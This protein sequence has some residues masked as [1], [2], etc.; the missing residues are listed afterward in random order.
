MAGFWDTLAL[1]NIIK[2]FSVVMPEGLASIIVLMVWLGF[3][4]EFCLITVVLA[5][6][7]EMLKVNARARISMERIAT[8]VYPSGS[9]K[10]IILPTKAKSY[11]EKMEGGDH[12][13]VI[14]PEG[15]MARSNGVQYTYLHPALPHN[16]SLNQ[17]VEF[18]TGYP[19][20]R[21]DENGQAQK[22]QIRNIIRSAQAQD[23]DIY[24]LAMAAS[25]DM[26]D[27]NKKI[28][29]AAIAIALILAV[30]GGLGIIF[31]LMPKPTGGEAAVAQAAV[32]T[33]TTT[34]Q[35]LSRMVAP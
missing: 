31:I 17:L 30:C 22:L 15:F 13:W 5:L 35:G 19:I 25:E 32:T 14:T 29:N 23:R 12:T 6:T 4:A 3:W 18:Y 10:D 20:E 11:T 8:I 27:P 34:L 1:F 9:T 24:E 16:V 7:K 21:T 26:T 28:T 2:L 33:T